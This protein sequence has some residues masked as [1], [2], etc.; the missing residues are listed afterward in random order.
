V[1]TEKAVEADY[2]I[3]ARSPDE[4]KEPLAMIVGGSA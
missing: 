2:L 4:M 1:F 3:E